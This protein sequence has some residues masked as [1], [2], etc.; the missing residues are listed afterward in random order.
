L[1]LDGPKCVRFGRSTA[2]KE[3]NLGVSTAKMGVAW[4]PEKKVVGP[5]VSEMKNSLSFHRFETVRIPYLKL[6]GKLGG[7]YGTNRN[8][9]LDGPK[10]LAFG[11]ETAEKEASLGVGTAKMGRVGP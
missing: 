8:P 1:G 2:E 4:V 9:K 10:C 7:Y 11:R 5:K 6:L 3:A